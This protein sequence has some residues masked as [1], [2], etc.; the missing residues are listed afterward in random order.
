MSNCPRIVIGPVR[1]S[2]STP[3]LRAWTGLTAPARALRPARAGVCIIPDL[4]PPSPSALSSLPSN[5]SPRKC[6]TLV[7]V[8]GRSAYCVLP[9]ALL[10][11]A[12]PSWTRL[13][14]GSRPGDCHPAGAPPARSYRRLDELARAAS[15]FFL[16]FAVA[17]SSLLPLIPRPDASGNG[18]PPAHGPPHG[19]PRR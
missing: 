17:S 9:V 4:L 8:T 11:N 16:P 2:A 12:T 15:P 6:R 3:R 18:L 19:R 14:R 10:K 1:R 7:A 13:T 5:Q